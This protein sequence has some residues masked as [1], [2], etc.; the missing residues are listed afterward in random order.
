MRRVETFHFLT[1]PYVVYCL[2]LALQWYFVFWFL[3]ILQWSRACWKLCYVGTV[4]LFG[5]SRISEW[6]LSVHLHGCLQYQ[7][8]IQRLRTC[9]FLRCRN[10]KN[11]K[12]LLSHITNTVRNFVNVFILF[13]FVYIQV[14]RNP[15]SVTHSIKMRNHIPI[16]TR[17]T[18]RN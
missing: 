14:Y 18:S 15:M 3:E 9:Q 16:H 2:L 8:M 13:R 7:Y 17:L 10:V 1:A 12:I 4:G 5:I 11:S 6:G